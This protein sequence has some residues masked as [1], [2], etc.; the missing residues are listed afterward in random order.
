MHVMYKYC[1]I[2]PY[3]FLIL[4]S[5]YLKYIQGPLPIDI[6]CFHFSS[7]VHKFLD[8]IRLQKLNKII[9]C[10]LILFINYFIMLLQLS[11]FKTNF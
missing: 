8:K 10:C 5:P 3:C 4:A 9:N 7:G 11:R 6:Q 1:Y 2:S